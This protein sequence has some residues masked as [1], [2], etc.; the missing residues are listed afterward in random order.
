MDKPVYEIP[1]DD[2]FSRTTAVPA[3]T[4]G[5]DSLRSQPPPSI[6]GD[7]VPRPWSLTAEFDEIVDPD[8]GVT[9]IA[10]LRTAPAM[11]RAASTSS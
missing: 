4:T 11:R 8:S 5:A 6:G 9:A 7:A 2:G 1:V 3:G 10:G